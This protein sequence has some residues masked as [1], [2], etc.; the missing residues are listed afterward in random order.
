MKRSE[1][2]PVPFGNNTV[3]E[4]PE[5]VFSQEIE[6][7]HGFGFSTGRSEPEPNKDSSRGKSVDELLKERKARADLIEHL[8]N[9]LRKDRKRGRPPRLRYPENKAQSESPDYLDDLPEPSKLQI[10]KSLQSN[11]QNPPCYAFDY[12]EW[13]A[14]L[15]M[16]LYCN[17]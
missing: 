17:E 13:Q 16:E 2:L 12:D 8:E 15:E 14:L 5:I 1:I 6:P 4:V 11:K 9:D 3:K 7:I 10:L